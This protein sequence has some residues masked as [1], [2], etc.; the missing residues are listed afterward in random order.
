MTGN[1]K[2]KT[3]LVT[4]DENENRRGE[5]LFAD[6]GSLQS[7]SLYD[8]YED[9]RAELDSMGHNLV[10]KRK[11]SYTLKILSLMTSFFLHLSFPDFCTDESP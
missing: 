1:A 7:D 2:I 5:T 3:L 6:L 9:S 4:G 11:F 10:S 8:S